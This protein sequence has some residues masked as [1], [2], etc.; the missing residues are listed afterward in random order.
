MKFHFSIGEPTQDWTEN[1]GFIDL[2]MIQK[3]VTPS[4]GRKRK[5]KNIYFKK[6][7]FILFVQMKI[8]ICGSPSMSIACLHALHLLN[9]TSEDIFI[10]GPF[11]TEQIRAVFGKNAKL[12]GHDETF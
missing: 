3:Y 10:Y 5:V 1:E 9:F 4:N 6:I 11:G 12:S 8:I 7:L 2:K